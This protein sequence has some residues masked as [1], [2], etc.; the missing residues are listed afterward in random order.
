MGNRPDI[1]FAV[2]Q[3]TRYSSEPKPEHWTAVMRILRYLKGTTDY[4][5]HFHR[6][7]SQYYHEYEQSK[8]PSMNHVKQ[9]FA[10]ASSFFPGTAK[11]NLT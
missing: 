1:T 4:G 7:N 8:R 10:Y 11:A 2:N 3:C 6:H 9:P 5:L